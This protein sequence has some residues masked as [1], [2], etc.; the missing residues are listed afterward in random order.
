MKK[1][2]KIRYLFYTLL[3]LNL[4]LASLSVAKAKGMLIPGQPSPLVIDNTVDLSSLTLKQKIAQM[5]VGLGIPDNAPAIKNLQL[6]GVYLYSMANEEMFKRATQ[7][8][9]AD[10]EIPFL[11]TVD[12]E[13]CFN[14]F[15]NFQNFTAANKISE[16]GEAFEKG[17][18]EGNFLSDLGV[19][20]NFAPVVD[21][22][23]TIWKCRSFPGDEQQISELANAYIL[24]LQDEKVYATAKHYPGKTLVIK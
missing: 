4:L 13:G 21:L 11:I 2:N 20:M 12:L 16:I 24:G 3:I 23:D 7:S 14:P 17:K 8:F 10:M 5:V 19:T 15:A 1:T 18:Q 6:G 9:Q 22:N